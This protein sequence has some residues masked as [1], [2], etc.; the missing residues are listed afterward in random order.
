MMFAE[1]GPSEAPI[2]VRANQKEERKKSV[3]SRK[4]EPRSPG[5]VSS[6]T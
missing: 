3:A 4:E 5:R 1:H 6:K 2:Q